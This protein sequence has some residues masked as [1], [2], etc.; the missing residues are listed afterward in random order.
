MIS[1]SI[2]EKK[3][4][5]EENILVLNAINENIQYFKK[6]NPHD[7]EEAAQRTYMVA[8]DNYSS[9]KGDIAPYIKKLAREIMKDSRNKEN[10][11][12]LVT[13]D[14]EISQ[15]FTVL[16][17]E[18]DTRNFDGAGVLLDAFKELYLMDEES[19]SKLEA[20]FTFDT[21]EELKVLSDLRIRNKGLFRELGKLRDKHGN[22]YFFR[23]LQTF[24]EQ[25]PSYTKK[26]KLHVT[27]IIDM[28][29][30]NFSLL[31]RISDTATIIDSN[32]K[33]HR[34][35]KTTLT[36]DTNPDYLTWD[37]VGSSMCDILR[38]DISDYMSYMYEEVLVDKGVWTK[39]I[40]W[41]DNKYKLTTPGG[42]VYVGLDR[43]KF[44][45]NV[46]IELILNLMANN[47]GTIVALSPDSI[48][49][50]PTRSFDFGSLRLKCK[51][52]RVI[53][54]PILTHI[55]KRR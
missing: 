49:I 9:N 32:G 33:Y 25:L 18:I 36:M 15:V 8:V 47:I 40:A 6:F 30:G 27:K 45:S 23:V 42:E 44:L 51:T 43:N 34:I 29:A 13:E 55:K 35:D 52:G 7:W 31:D 12:D 5:D 48:Y 19:F 1:F 4:M 17:T 28:K 24:F 2:N 41:C 26:R 46:R 16:K 38:V 3:G 54:L 37:L 21:S 14:G 39:H 53:D 10:T 20:I 22:D 11:Y 50:K